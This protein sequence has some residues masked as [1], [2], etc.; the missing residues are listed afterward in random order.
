[1]AKKC[2]DSKSC[3]CNIHS[4][5]VSVVA[6]DLSG[7]PLDPNVVATLEAQLQTFA[8]AQGLILCITRK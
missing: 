8:Q 6:Y 7:A 1:M 4:N 3:M 5:A 2:L